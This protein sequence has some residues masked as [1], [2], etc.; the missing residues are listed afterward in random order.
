ML[1]KAKGLLL[2]LIIGLNTFT[3]LYSQNITKSP[4]SIIGVGDIVF[5]G[6]AA[7]YSMGQ[8]TQGIRGP[9]SQNMLNP[10][11]YSSLL[12]TSIE[13]GAVYSQGQFSGS[14]QSTNVNNAWI[15]YLNFGIPMGSGGKT[16]SFGLTPVSGVGYN[17]QSKVKM[18][19]DSQQI[20]ALYYFKGRGGL[21]QFYAG[22]G[23]KLS[24]DTASLFEHISLGV[25]ANY[26]FGQITNTTQLLIPPQYLMFNLNE[27]KTSYIHG[28]K[29]DIGIQVNDSF[30]IGTGSAS[31]D[32]YWVLGAT[33]SPA[34]L[35]DV[36]Q[37]YILRTL[38]IGA[39][40]G[41]RDTIEN[42]SISGKVN[43][44]LSWRA[45]FSYGVVAEQYRWLLAADA[46]AT[47]WSS[48][49]SFNKSD[50]LRDNYGFS[51]GA[52]ITPTLTGVKSVLNNVEYRLGYRYEQSNLSVN[53]TGVNVWAVTAGFGIPLSKTASKLNIGFEYM[54]RG[55]TDNNLIQENYFRVIVGISF[56]DKW[57]H[58]TRYE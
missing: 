18:D 9:Y 12:V 20:D 54:Q 49:K 36:E 14:A 43:S 50:S 52:S 58:K 47:N 17:I 10:A 6:S 13:A 7:N 1:N 31:T 57:F 41:I 35:L 33:V 55:T 19:G 24:T 11:S 5:A 8:V 29:A 27:D 34:R 4:Y 16:L 56:A 40:T 48:Y 30:T 51:L 32:H 42:T 2:G 26:V 38:P 3:C 28:W 44:P 21:S 39:T 15:G 53:G 46:K 22:Y 25:N 45:G 23:F 37:N